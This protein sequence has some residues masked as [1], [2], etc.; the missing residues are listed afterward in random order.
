ML[1]REAYEELERVL[2]LNT[3]VGRREFHIG[4][5]DQSFAC[6]YEG[7][8][9]NRPQMDIKR[10]TCDIRTREETIISRHILHQHRYTFHIVFPVL[11][12]PQYRSILTVVSAIPHLRSNL[13]VISETFS[14]KTESFYATNTSHRKQIT[15]L[16]ECP[17]Y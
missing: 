12:N 17:S 5:Q 16:Y 4:S 9:V 14:T 7:E 10:K 2:G 8:S 15:F 1:Q 6:S 3:N 13:F 11:R